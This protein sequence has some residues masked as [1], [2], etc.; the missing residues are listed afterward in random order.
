MIQPIT[1][2]GAVL[3]FWV[4]YLKYRSQP[5]DR[6]RSSPKRRLGVVKMLFAAFVAWMALSFTLQHMLAKLDGPLT[7]EPSMLERVITFFK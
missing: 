2:L 7:P 1:L 3:C 4:L 6:P 5:K